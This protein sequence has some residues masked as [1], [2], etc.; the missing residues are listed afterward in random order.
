MTRSSPRPPRRSPS[1][2]PASRPSTPAEQA[3]GRSRRDG[4]DP[5]LGGHRAESH[6]R[7][8]GARRE[9]AA[10]IALLRRN[11]RSSNLYVVELEDAGSATALLERDHGLLADELVRAALEDLERWE[12]QGIQVYTV[13]DPR[14][15]ANLRAAVDRPALI[16]VVGEYQPSDARSVAVIGSRSASEDGLALAR[17]V[18]EELVDSS[19]TVVSGLAAGVDAAA[20]SV[21]LPRRGRTIAVIGTGVRRAYPA[22]NAALQ[23]R[24]AA[25]GAVISQFLPDAG[26]SRR[27]FPKRNAVMS[28][29]T[30]ATVVIEAS[31]TS[32]AR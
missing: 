14:Y 7:A 6:A 21:A 17:A 9:P 8:V 10:L 28:G 25:E 20:H 12:D 23:R 13:L 24:I 31:S 16:F 29:L 1:S 4:R 32:G 3:D 5:R 30:L 15:P 2:Q 19:Y 22:E 27:S 11:R 26:P 18:V